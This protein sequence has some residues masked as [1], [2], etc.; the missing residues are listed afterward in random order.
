MPSSRAVAEGAS[1]LQDEYE[2]RRVEVVGPT[3][4]GRTAPGTERWA[5]CRSAGRRC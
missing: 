4:L 1:E 5:C 2:F 3:V